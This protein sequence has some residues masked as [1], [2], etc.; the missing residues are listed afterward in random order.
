MKNVLQKKKK[1][2]AREFDKFRSVVKQTLKLIN[3]VLGRKETVNSFPLCVDG[4]PIRAIMQM[5]N[6]FNNYFVNVG[7]DLAQNL[8][9]EFTSNFKNFMRSYY[10][11]SFFLFTVKLEEVLNVI[12]WLE[13]NI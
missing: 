11:K 9:T 4:L 1:N 8:N 12:I 3:S 7:S 2:Y 6:V 13:S 5:C 10:K